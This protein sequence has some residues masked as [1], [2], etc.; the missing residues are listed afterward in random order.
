MD[1]SHHSDRPGVTATNSYVTLWPP[2]TNP[3][4][5]RRVATNV[6]C[7]DARLLRWPNIYG[8]G[9]LQ[10]TV[11]DEALGRIASG[12][13]Q[14]PLALPCDLAGDE[15]LDFLLEKVAD[16][17]DDGRNPYL[18]GVPMAIEML[19]VIRLLDGIRPR[20][21]EDVRLL[22][23]IG[24]AFVFYPRSRRL[25]RVEPGLVESRHWEGNFYLSSP[26][27]SFTLGGHDLLDSGRVLASRLKVHGSDCDE[28]ELDTW[29]RSGLRDRLRAQARPSILSDNDSEGGVA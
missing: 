6:S 23:G 10:L 22:R 15:V 2:S 19:H 7:D 17:C 8:K 27:W 1:D 26:L 20:V 3:H 21:G 12:S 5:A 18:S 28:R 24:F 11:I 25:S 4:V 14:T 9:S 13:L 16:A 29:L